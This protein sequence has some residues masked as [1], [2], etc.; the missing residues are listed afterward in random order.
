MKSLNVEGKNTKVTKQMIAKAE[1]TQWWY[2]SQ[3][4]YQ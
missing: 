2:N 4:Y 1:R 3:S